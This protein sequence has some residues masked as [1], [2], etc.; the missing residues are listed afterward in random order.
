MRL[1]GS[2]LLC[3]G[4]CLSSAPSKAAEFQGVFNGND[5]YEA[6][7]FNRTSYCAPIVWGVFDGIQAATSAETSEGVMFCFPPG[8][9]HGQQV[10]I[11]A[12][13]E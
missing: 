1:I 11:V 12:V 9:T 6:C 10:G 5:I 7:V 8:A 4:V 3:G 13:P 2:L